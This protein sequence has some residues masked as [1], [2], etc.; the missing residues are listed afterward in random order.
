MKTIRYNIHRGTGLWSKVIML[1]SKGTSH[2]SFDLNGVRWQ[3]DA[4]MGVERDVYSTSP[5]V[6]RYEQKVSNKRMAELEKWIVE[7]EGKDYD[8]LGVLANV[9]FFAKPKMGKWYCSELSNV[10][11]MKSKGIP[12][13]LMQRNKVTPKEFWEILESDKSIKRI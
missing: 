10:I 1:F 8:F 6:A 4:P 3:S 11:Y 7:Q 5:I 13:E 2:V 12:S 9:S